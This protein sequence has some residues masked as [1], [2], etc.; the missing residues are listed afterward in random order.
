[1]P[2]RELLELR[3]LSNKT[4]H[5]GG[6]EDGTVIS[7]SDVKWRDTKVITTNE[8]EVLRSIVKNETEHSSEL[9]AYIKRWTALLIDG[10]NNLTI[11]TRLRIVWGLELIVQFLVVV[12]FSIGSDNYVSIV[13]D[14]R[15]RSRF[16][17]HNGETLMGNTVWQGDPFIGIGTY[18]QV[19]RPIWTAMTKTRA[20]SD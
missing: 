5:L 19:P 11:R 2:R 13:G 15:L 7:P 3:A 10:E 9:L 12:N 17:I 14:Q 8:E 18:D 16:R 6:D 20:A 4:L 1:V